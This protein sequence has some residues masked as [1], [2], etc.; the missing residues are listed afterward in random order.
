M[1]FAIDN[2][3]SSVAFEVQPWN[4]QTDPVP[5]K[6]QNNKAEFIKWCQKPSTKNC[7]FST[8]E[9]LDPMRRVSADNPIVLIYGVVADF[10]ARITPDMLKALI[11]ESP[12]EFA[13]N[14]GSLTYS[15]G[16][17][18]VWLFAEP[19]AVPSMAMAKT[20]YKVIMKKLK[21]IK[22]LPGLDVDA[23]HDP[24]K[25]YEKGRDWI[26]ISGTPIPK[27][28]V[29]Q[30][31]Y[32][33]GNKIKWV[34]S[35]LTIPMDLVAK[36]IQKQYPGRWNGPFE[37]GVRCPRFWE[38]GYDPAT[39]DPTGVVIRA[40]GVQC[41]S[42]NSG[43][44]PW[45]AIL[46]DEFVSQYEAD[47]TGEII[48]SLFYDGRAYW[49]QDPK[50]QWILLSK[51]DLRLMLKVK[52]GLN[53]YAARKET[54]SELERVTFAI[55]DQKYVMA[56]MPFVH[57]PT[58]IFY[59]GN[60]RYLNTSTL[61]CLPPADEAGVW[62]E[63]FPWLAEFL[64][65]FFDP[66]EQLEYFLAWWKH[67]Y[68]NG[69]KLDPQS[70][71]AIFIAGA[72]GVGKTLLS[73]GIVSKSVGGHVDA[74][75]YFLG[76]EKFTSHIVSSPIMSVDDTV[77]ASD[78]RRHTRY[79]AMIK[80]IVANRYHMYEEKYQ[81]A[82]QITWQGRVM[83]SC[84]TDPE[85][86]RLLPDPDLSLLDKISLFKC[87]DRVRKFPKSKELQEILDRELPHFLAWLLEWEIPE[88]C[89]GASRFG[90]KSYHEQH[91]FTASLQTSASFSFL[92]LLTAFLEKLQEEGPSKAYWEG[93]A[94]E[95]LSDM[96]VDASLGGLASKYTPNQVAT[97][98]GQLASR[99]F[100]LERERNS[101]RRAW[102]IPFEVA[103]TAKAREDIMKTLV[104]RENKEAK[105]Y[106]E[107]NDTRD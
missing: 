1:L 99:G 100:R 26:K 83:V 39:Y 61:T 60:A 82:G 19:V 13:P 35:D 70:G 93:T 47:R 80:K 11:T 24:C 56:A 10:D 79:S 57:F 64:D 46:G 102:K 55:Q 73:T 49:R 17:R 41:F 37:E 91:L 106:H 44:L 104:R 3:A 66:P 38:D 7:H 40:S 8:A 6:A 48:S 12:T 34:G 86:V 103:D 50:G 21:V 85:S 15:G 98:L 67:F 53:A 63:K 90:I 36:E 74:S 14:W 84:N 71:Q 54:S 97:Y 4:Y 33:A 59:R 68:E 45:S 95:L 52:Y 62:G 30:W 96:M 72:P 69:L 94:T 75:S 51:E 76:E 2:L 101:Q 25:Y 28:F 22:C 16:G 42:G 43:F 20:F 89:I 105:K 58:G 23:F 107:T 18:L 87:A 92:E 31:M 32:E 29:H 9:G 81:K 77:P 5:L 65:E 27:N 88:H 78:A